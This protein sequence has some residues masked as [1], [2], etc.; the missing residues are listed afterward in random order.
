MRGV[1]IGNMRMLQAAILEDIN[2]IL[3]F[4]IKKGS[5]LI[6]GP[7]NRPISVKQV[8]RDHFQA[9]VTANFGKNL[10]F[11]FF[12]IFVLYYQFY[13]VPNRL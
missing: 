3:L 13:E 1:A 8:I 2:L 7:A 9:I 6:P 11:S 12:G 10:D 5:L 4:K